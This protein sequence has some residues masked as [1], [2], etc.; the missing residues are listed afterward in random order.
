M[1]ADEFKEIWQGVYAKPDQVI[2]KSKA[3]S[4][5]RWLQHIKAQLLTYREKLSLSPGAL[6]PRLSDLPL[7]ASITGSSRI[8]DFGGSSA[9]TYEFLQATVKKNQISDYLCIEIESVVE[10]MNFLRLHSPPVRYSSNLAS[11]ESNFDIFYANSSIQYVLDDAV[12]LK[13]INKIRPKWLL[14]ED[15]LGGDVDEFYTI[16]NYYGS[17]IPVKIRNSLNF[18]KLFSN[19]DL[20]YFRPYASTILGAVTKPPMENFPK[21]LQL[22]C[23]W[24]MLL[25]MKP[26]E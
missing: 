22:D 13:S 21:E 16:Q 4:G 8:I 20:I 12:L 7:L 10:F 14:I 17:K 11:I 5:N 2:S 25:R 3:F 24:S 23:S 15:F 9:W 19:Y 6:P 26:Q 1:S 18:I